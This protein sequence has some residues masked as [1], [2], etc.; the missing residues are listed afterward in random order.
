MEAP[1]E[2][3]TRRALKRD[4]HGAQGRF[5]SWLDNPAGRR[6]LGTERDVLR[7]VAR[8]LHGDVLVWLGPCPDMLDTTSRSMV[9]LRVF[10]ADHGID[11]RRVRPQVPAENRFDVVGAD[12]AQLPFA[13]GSVDAVVFHHALDMACDRRAALREAERIL[14]PGGRLVVLGFN[15][16]SL[17]SLAKQ[18]GPLRDLRSISV[19]RLHEWLGLLGLE[20]ETPTIYLNFRS[21]LP[22]KLDGGGWRAASD[23][24]NRVQPPIGG[25]YLLVARKVGYGLIVQRR[26]GAARRLKSTAPVLPNPTRIK[27]RPNIAARL[28]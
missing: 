18:R 1:Q 9:R 8:Q 14:K 22:V 20:R 26:R 17:W 23:W 24:L 4:L 25:V 12:S 10:A 11:V 5:A 3:D 19:P 13:P 28:G 16:L 2:R 6:L 15:P 27:A 7:K 21:A